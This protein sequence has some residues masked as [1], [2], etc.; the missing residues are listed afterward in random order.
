MNLFIK[1]PISDKS[2]ESWCR[3]LR[4]SGE[5]Q[6]Q[7]RKKKTEMQTKRLDMCTC[8][9]WLPWSAVDGPKNS[10]VELQL[11]GG[12][13]QLSEN[14]VIILDLIYAIKRCD[15]LAGTVALNQTQT[16]LQILACGT[17][18]HSL[19][20]SNQQCY[21]PPSIQFASAFNQSHV[22][23]VAELKRLYFHHHG[24]HE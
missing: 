24:F 11:G 10:Y 7:R 17:L 8:W 9:F 2:R 18:S 12:G 14:P 4:V 20:I 21:S 3:R 23:R 5:D 13:V 6:R 15:Q 16:P 1:Q 19:L 22:C